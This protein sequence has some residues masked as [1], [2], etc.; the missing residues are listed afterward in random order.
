M[1]VQLLSLRGHG[2]EQRTSGI[3]QIL[4][5]MEHLFIYQEILLLRTD[6]GAHLL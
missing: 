5:L 2:A 3:N 6:A 4:T 1:I